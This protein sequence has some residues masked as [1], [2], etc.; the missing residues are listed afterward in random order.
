MGND[1]LEGDTSELN[2]EEV[3]YSYILNIGDRALNVD[4]AFMVLAAYEQYRAANP[5]VPTTMSAVD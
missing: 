1:L 2:D 3:Q 4:V 5:T